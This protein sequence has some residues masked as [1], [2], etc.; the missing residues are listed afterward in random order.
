MPRAPIGTLDSGRPQMLFER[1][2]QIERLSEVLD[3]VR[4]GAGRLILLEGPAGVG[5]TALLNEARRLAG[6]AGMGTLVA[7]AGEFERDFPF[8]IVRQ[9]L[10]PPVVAASDET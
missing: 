8:A 10:E 4:A 1:A 9:L 2:A 3:E 7:H 6:A 5:K